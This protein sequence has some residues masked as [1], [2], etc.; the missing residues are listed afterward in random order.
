MT[1]LST[2][3]LSES[4]SGRAIEAA[5]GQEIVIR[6]GS[7]P[8]TGYRWTLVDPGSSVLASRGAPVYTPSA[9]VPGVMGGGGT[10]TWSFTAGGPGQQDLR[11]EYRQPWER[12]A[13]PARSVGYTIRVRAE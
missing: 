2:I 7:N 4:D 8:S 9:A 1:P 13:P 6:L 11:F 10:E 12:E 3:T 5:P